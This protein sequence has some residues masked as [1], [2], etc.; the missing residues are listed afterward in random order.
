MKAEDLTLHIDNAGLMA[1]IEILQ[2]H[3]EQNP[4]IWEC[5]DARFPNHA[6]IIAFGETSTVS[7]LVLLPS[8]AFMSFIQDLI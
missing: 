4:A 5:F 8:A 7:E 6:D 2:N 3:A 1:A